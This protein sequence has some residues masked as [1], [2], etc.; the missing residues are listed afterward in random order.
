MPRSKRNSSAWRERKAK[1]VSEI[2]NQLVHKEMELIE[3]LTVVHERW[4]PP[5][6]PGDFQLSHAVTRA[7]PSAPARGPRRRSAAGVEARLTSFVRDGNGCDP[8]DKITGKFLE[9]L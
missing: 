5:H 1:D 9:Y 3:K 4:P 2:V 8:A 6:N 7:V